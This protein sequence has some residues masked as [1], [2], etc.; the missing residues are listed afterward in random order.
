MSEFKFNPLTEGIEE[1]RSSWGWL[2][3]LG[4][5]STMLGTGCL[6]FSVSATFA[7]VLVFGWVL[8]IGGVVAVVQAF[9]TGTWRGFT[10]SAP[11]SAA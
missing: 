10:C 1:I 6:A 4:I 9:R 8:L 2:L 7:T 3:A 11:F 5:I